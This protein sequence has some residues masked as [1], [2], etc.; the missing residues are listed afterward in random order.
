LGGGSSHGRK[1]PVDAS[2]QGVP[3]AGSTS[4]PHEERIR[5]QA[6]LEKDYDG[7]V[8]RLSGTL[9]SHDRAA[10]ALHDAYLRLSGSPI[11]G[12][13]R[14]PIAY[15]YRMALNLAHNIRVR[16]LRSVGLAP[17][18]AEALPDDDPGP[19]R[20]ALG[21]IDLARTLALL[22]ALPVQR[23]DIFLARW[24]DELGQ[25][26][27]ARRFRLHKRTVQKELAKAERY[28]HAQIRPIA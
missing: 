12:E 27:I 17:T 13:V 23:R 9:Q 2:G 5:L 8:H 22:D 25:D 14:N 6:A 18:I 7:L 16:D 10:D 3:D 26:E 11:I 21:R 20:S 28:L 15:L 24:R 4:S 1:Q 19:E